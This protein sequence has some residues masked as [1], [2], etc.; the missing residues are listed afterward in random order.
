MFSRFFLTIYVMILSILLFSVKEFWCLNKRY[1]LVILLYIAAQVLSVV[2]PI[3]LYMFYEFDVMSVV[4]YVNVI[5]FVLA[6]FGSFALM[7]KDLQKE[8]AEHPLTAS[9]IIGWTILGVFLAWSAQIIA[10]T[11]ETSVFGINQGS[12]NTAEIVELTRMSPIFFIIPV[13]T[14]PILEEFIFRKIIFG[15]LYK[16][17]N[18]F[19]AVLISSLLF[20]VLHLELQRLLIYFAMGVALAYVYVKTKR[21]IVPIL[22]HMGMNTVAIL[23]QLL[24]DPEELERIQQEVSLILFGG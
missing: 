19:I 6:V 12:E 3:F 14:A 7:R 8:K 1:W 13:F 9:K 17:M 10:I 15:S 21:I 2:I 11:I 16:R 24:I 5:L 18:F 23:G 20:G 4:V 22:V